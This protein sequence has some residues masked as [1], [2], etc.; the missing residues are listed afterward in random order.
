[1]SEEV[2]PDCE[3]DRMSKIP[4]PFSFLCHDCKEQHIAIKLDMWQLDW[5]NDLL[6]GYRR[7]QKSHLK[8]EMWNGSDTELCGMLDDEINMSNEMLKEI[9]RPAIKKLNKDMKKELHPELQESLK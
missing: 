9:V 3:A 4:Y 6:L 8:S 7:F 1:M 5:L 2:C